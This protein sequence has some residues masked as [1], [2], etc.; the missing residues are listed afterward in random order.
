M[1]TRLMLFLYIM[2]CFYSSRIRHTRCALVT[3]VQTCALP[4]CTTVLFV[5]HDISEA[6][7]LG[8]RVAVMHQGR[9]RADIPVD[10]AAPRTQSM[11]HGAAF[12]GYCARVFEAMTGVPA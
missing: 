8:D 11:R 9:M 7:Y 3:G 5:T 12:N 10:L 2:F 4:I 6:V 1:Y